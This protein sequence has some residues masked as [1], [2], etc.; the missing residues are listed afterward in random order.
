M[1]GHIHKRVRKTRAGKETTRWYVVVDVGINSNGR[2]RQKWHGGFATRREA[3][4]ARA[5]IVNDLHTGSYVA[6]DRLTLAEWV[7]ESWLPM[8][9]TRIKPSTFDSYRANMEIHVLPALGSRPL[10]QLTAPLL[11]AL[12]AQLLARG[13]G[14]GPL[15]SK[16]VSYIHTIAHKALAGRVQGAGVDAK[17]PPGTRD[18]PR[19]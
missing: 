8:I 11:N 12:Y 16:T 10:Q 2:R 17:E 14:R 5:K 13:N 15:G 19:P 4:A 18:R 3:E 9:R 1:R 6:P 7:R